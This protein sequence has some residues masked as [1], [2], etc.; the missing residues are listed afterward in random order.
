MDVSEFLRAEPGDRVAAD[1]PIAQIET[2]KVLFFTFSSI[3]KIWVYTPNTCSVYFHQVTIDVVSPQD[4]VIQ[5][6]IYQ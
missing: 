3:E 1:E 6:V 5:E 4:G 2:D